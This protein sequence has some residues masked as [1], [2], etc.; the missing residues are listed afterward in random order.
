MVNIGINSTARESS[1]AGYWGD[2]GPGAAVDGNL[3]TD[4]DASGY[5]FACTHTTDEV[6]CDAK[7]TRRACTPVVHELFW[8]LF[9]RIA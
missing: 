2:R 4:F 6:S 3:R 8:N 5:P 7:G 9:H 1:R